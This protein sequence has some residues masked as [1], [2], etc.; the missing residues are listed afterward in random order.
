[1]ESLLSLLVEDLVYSEWFF[2]DPIV[3]QDTDELYARITKEKWAEEIR[4][5]TL[6]KLAT[7]EKKTTTIDLIAERLSNREDMGSE[8]LYRTGRESDLTSYK[9]AHLDI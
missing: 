2:T 5:Y 3:R 7:E 6:C 8:H 1:M 4:L 9:I